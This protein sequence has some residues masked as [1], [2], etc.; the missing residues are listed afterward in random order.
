MKHLLLTLFSL[1]VS[2]TLLAY[3][4]EIDG[5]YYNF[6]GDEAE[7]TYNRVAGKYNM[8]SPDYSGV[9]EIPS[10]VSYEGKT[11]SVTSIGMYSFYGCDALVSI[12]I[13]ES[14]TSIGVHSF[15][16]CK[17]LNSITIPEGITR[18]E[19]FTF[20][21]CSS[22]GNVSIP[23]GVT[24]IGFNAFYECGSLEFINIP[25]SVNSIWGYA[26]DRCSSLIS[27]SFPEGV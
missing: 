19:D 18:I 1:I 7:V 13:P 4:A 10:S 20:C 5:I 26:F 14:V 27:F 2:T 6:S 22:L 24:D 25:S 21:G 9:I 16:G 8:P 12:N 15:E 23:E 17:G 11:Y 3:D